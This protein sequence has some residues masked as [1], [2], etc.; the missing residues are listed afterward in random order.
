MQSLL[1]SLSSP[2]FAQ[3]VDQVDAVRLEQFVRQATAGWG[4]SGRRSG[5]LRQFQ[6]AHAQADLFQNVKRR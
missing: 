5:H 4:A 6:V 2:T 3:T 1:R